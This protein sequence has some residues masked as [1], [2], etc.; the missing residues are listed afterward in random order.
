MSNSHLS[1]S[2][3]TRTHAYIHTLKRIDKTGLLKCEEHAFGEGGHLWSCASY[4]CSTGTKCKPTFVYWNL[5]ALAGKCAAKGPEHRNLGGW[6]LRCDNA[7]THSDLLM[8]QFL[9]MNIIVIQHLPYLQDFSAA[10][11]LYFSKTQN[12]IKG[13]EV[14]RCHHNARE[15]NSAPYGMCWMWCNLCV[16]SQG[17]YFEW[18]ITV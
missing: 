16:G 5:T 10:F 14:W 18:D 1:L 6:F 8:L 17:D 7:F 12:G 11:L 4:I 2:T 15:S 3:H 13:K 9:A